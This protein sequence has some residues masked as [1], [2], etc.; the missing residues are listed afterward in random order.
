M[1]SA[2]KEFTTFFQRPIYFSTYYLCDHILVVPKHL[3]ASHNAWNKA[4]FM[5]SLKKKMY[6]LLGLG[7]RLGLEEYSLIQPVCRE[8]YCVS[9]TPGALG[10][11]LW[12]IITSD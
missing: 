5:G 9:H 3:G 6:I 7:L 2:S 8:C 12:E 11:G 1:A 10:S 4:I